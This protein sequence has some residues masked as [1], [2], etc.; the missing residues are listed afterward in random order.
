MHPLCNIFPLIQKF[1]LFPLAGDER[2]AYEFVGVTY[3]KYM[4]RG[5]LTGAEYVLG[6]SFEQSI[7]DCANRCKIDLNCAIFSFDTAS[8]ICLRMHSISS[9]VFANDF[10]AE[11]QSLT[12]FRVRFMMLPCYPYMY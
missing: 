2:E 10:R 4:R 3:R 11:N 12:Y 7:N 1:S 8:R 9:V 6:S 5:R